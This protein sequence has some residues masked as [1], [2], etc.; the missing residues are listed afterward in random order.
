MIQNSANVREEDDKKKRHGSIRLGSG[1]VMF[2]W[3]FYPFRTI[4]VSINALI[5]TTNTMARKN[6]SKQQRR[7]RPCQEWDRWR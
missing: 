4:I 6:D 7:L 1:A 3:S 2:V 5:K